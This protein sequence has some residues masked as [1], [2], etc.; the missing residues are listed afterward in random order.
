MPRVSERGQFKAVAVPLL[1]KWSQLR[2][3][4]RPPTCE[5]GVEPVHDLPPVQVHVAEHHHAVS[6]VIQL[7]AHQARHVV[8][9]QGRAAEEVQALNVTVKKFSFFKKFDLIIVAERDG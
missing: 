8:A 9:A 1:L 2:T 4:P 7:L 6:L 3:A 5:E